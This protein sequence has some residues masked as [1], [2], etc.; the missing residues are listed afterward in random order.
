MVKLTRLRQ[1][2]RFGDNLLEIRPRQLLLYSAVPK[3]IC[4]N[5]STP[6]VRPDSSSYYCMRRIQSA[7]A[8][9]DQTGFPRCV[10]G[11]KRYLVSH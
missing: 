9:T 3:G 6:S 2:F 10:H 7:A 8:D 1:H 11:D 5:I 4:P